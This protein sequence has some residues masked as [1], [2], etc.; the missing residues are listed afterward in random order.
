MYLFRST[1]QVA[2]VNTLPTTNTATK[3]NRT[4]R[5][6]EDI[7]LGTET[8]FPAECLPPTIPTV[9][10]GYWI[11]SRHGINIR[12]KQWRALDGNFRFLFDG[13][14]MF[15]SGTTFWWMFMTCHIISSL[16]CFLIF[17]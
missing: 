13:R 6:L 10:K 14:L 7:E 12:I 15:G 11:P 2:S 5:N 9:D 17:E 8:C 16:I 4:S 1:N 3:H